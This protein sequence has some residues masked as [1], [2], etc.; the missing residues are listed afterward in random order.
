MQESSKGYNLNYTSYQLVSPLDNSLDKALYVSEEAWHYNVPFLRSQR[1]GTHNNCIKLLLHWWILKR[2]TNGD[3]I[4][5]GGQKA[6][7]ENN[8]DKDW[9]VCYACMM[10]TAPIT[11]NPEKKGLL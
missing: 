1:I 10:L 9:T 5:V 3:T 4:T 8:I 11:I 2:Q 6:T 7:L